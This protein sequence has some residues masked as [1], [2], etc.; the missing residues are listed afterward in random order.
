[1]DKDVLVS[2]VCITN[3]RGGVT[4]LPKG[5]Y[6]V[7]ITEDRDYEPWDHGKGYLLDKRAIVVARKCGRTGMGG[8][9]DPSRVYFFASN[10]IKDL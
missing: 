5:R 7:R 2:E 9:F 8:K 3:D 1:M 4:Y 6:G 10:I